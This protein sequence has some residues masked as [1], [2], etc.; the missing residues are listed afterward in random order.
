MKL[1]DENCVEESEEL[2]NENFIACNM[3]RVFQISNTSSNHL[4]YKF[5]LIGKFDNMIEIDSPMR[6]I[7]YPY[8]YLNVL[9]ICKLYHSLDWDDYEI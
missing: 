1:D 7:I 9:R 3:I 6:G 8:K 4:Y 2:N 5:K